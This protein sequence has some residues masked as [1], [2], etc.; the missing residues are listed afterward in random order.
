MEESWG[1]WC[2]PWA[3]VEPSP[4]PLTHNMHIHMYTN[5]TADTWNRERFSMCLLNEDFLWS[6]IS[7]VLDFVCFDTGY[8]VAQWPQTGCAVTNLNSFSCL[9]FPCLGITSH[10]WFSNYFKTNLSSF[11]LWRWS[12]CFLITHF[13]DTH[14]TLPFNIMFTII[15]LQ[16]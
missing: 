15:I 11:I 9:Y 8:H 1:T 5:H 10:I 4:S 13:I 14:S 16:K 3:Y 2:L 12:V 7:A 6:K